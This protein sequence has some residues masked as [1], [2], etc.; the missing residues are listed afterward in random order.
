MMLI[1]L[2]QFRKQDKNP[3][4]NPSSGTSGTQYCTAP[5][6]PP[7]KVNAHNMKPATKPK[8]ELPPQS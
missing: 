2:P 8:T 6:K 3:P 7:E 4:P 1:G 5:G